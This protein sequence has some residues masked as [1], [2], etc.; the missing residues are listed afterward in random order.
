VNDVRV[1]DW[2]DPG[3]LRT[4]SD[5]FLAQYNELRVFPLPIE[6]IVE[7]KLGINII[8]IPGLQDR[9]GTVGFFFE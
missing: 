8:D 6:E 5:E 9:L 1:V 2:I 7:F 3:E 4:L